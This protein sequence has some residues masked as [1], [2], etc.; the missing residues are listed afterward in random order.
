MKI[1]KLMLIVS[2]MSF[3]IGSFG[4]SLNNNLNLEVT[5]ELMVEFKSDGYIVIYQGR[6]E[7][8]VDVLVNEA[9]YLILKND[10]GEIVFEKTIDGPAPVTFSNTEY[11]PGAY[12][13]TVVVGGF[14]KDYLVEIPH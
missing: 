3:S 12:T 11:S 5:C 10:S 14:D 2:I 6:S 13:L 9:V 4:N 7:L 8:V 1:I